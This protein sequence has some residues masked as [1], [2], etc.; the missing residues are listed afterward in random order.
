MEVWA[1]MPEIRISNWMIFF[2]PAV[3]FSKVLFGNEM[4]LVKTWKRTVTHPVRKKDQRLRFQK[5]GIISALFGDD[6]SRET[7]LCCF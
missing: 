4:N 7:N 1:Q 2:L 5:G 6:G 3:I